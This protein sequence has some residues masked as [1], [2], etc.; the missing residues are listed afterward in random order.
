MENDTNTEVTLFNLLKGHQ[1]DEFKKYIESIDN[2]DVNIRDD[3]NNYLLTYAILYNKPDIV[4]LL[5]DKGA[6]ID[7][8]DRRNRSILYLAINYNYQ[9]IIDILLDYNK[10]TIGIFLFDIRDKNNDVPI[11]YTILFNNITAL[12]KLLNAGANP[13]TKDKNGYNSLHLAV[14]MRSYKMCEILVKYNIDINARC[15]SGETALHIA[16]NLQK[17]DIVKLLIDSGINVNIQDYDHEFTALHYS[18]TLNNKELVGLL[19]KN[20]A[21]PNIQDVA[22]N[23]VL[24]YAVSENNLECLAIILGSSL[25]NIQ[26][27]LW[28]LDGKIALLMALEID[29][30]NIAEYID[31]LLPKSNLN[32]Q[33]NDGNTCMHL[34]CGKD[35]WKEYKLALSKKR[36]DIFLPNKMNIRPIDLVKPKDIDVFIDMVV[37]SYLYRLRNAKALWKEEWENLC[38]KEL[39]Y[40]ILSENEKKI[41]KVNNG[42]LESTVDVCRVIVRNKLKQIY[43]RKDLKPCSKS[44]PIKHGTFCIDIAEGKTVNVC[45]FTGDPMDILIGLIYILRTHPDACSTFSRNFSENKELC[46]FYKSIGIIMNTRC[47]FLN[48]EI[49][50]A[51]HKL[52]LME[53]FYENFKKC[54]ARPD[55]RYIVIPIGIEMRSGGHANYLLY[56]K[57]THEVERFEPHG[58]TA[59]LGLNY[60]PALLDDILETRFKEMDPLVKYI[61]PKDY[62]PKIGFQLLDIYER[63]RKKIGD[64]GGFCALWTI[65]Y[66]DMRLSNKDIDRKVL[67]NKMIQTIKS[68]NISFKNLIRNYARNIIDIRDR[69]LNKAQLDINDWLNDQYTD[70]QIDIIL[71]EITREVSQLIP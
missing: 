17:L 61:R 22:G 54:L 5:I 42:D 32:I 64:P 9:E 8:V 39:Y 27:N 29:A 23:T 21:N 45:T 56:D 35:L 24:H 58:S 62:L 69:I 31:I 36:L 12:Q 50:W 4:K 33:D 26:F 16:C 44:Y 68:Q 51:Y 28:N 3:Q 60:N 55:K 18:V 48:F 37:D 34:F 43:E 57:K 19:L 6:R 67:V 46:K 66:I 1:W 13:N 53:D 7:I 10:D 52:Y 47:E 40:G 71:K 49:V 25:Y 38:K 30:Q 20:K 14:Y 15:N 65:W 70:S 11:H 59:P 63:K 41:L 2:I